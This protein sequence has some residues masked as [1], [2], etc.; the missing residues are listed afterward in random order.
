MQIRMFDYKEKKWL[1][2]GGTRQDHRTQAYVFDNIATAVKVA[3]QAGIA[4]EDMI[5]DWQLDYPSKDS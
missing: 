5:P 4:D 3:H 2:S 1:G